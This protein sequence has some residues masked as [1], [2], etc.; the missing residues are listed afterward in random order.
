MVTRFAQQF[1][2]YAAPGLAWHFGDTVTYHPGGSGSRPIQAMIE[3]NVQVISDG[4]EV[5]VYDFVLRVLDNSTTGIAATEID[6]GPDQ[7]TVATRVGE[8]PLRR[9]IVQ[10][11]ST[12]NGLVRFAV[13]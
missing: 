7:V 2:R 11:I 9:Q 6:T 1:G 12:E 4:G 5:V 13:Q 8:A 10:V 3:R